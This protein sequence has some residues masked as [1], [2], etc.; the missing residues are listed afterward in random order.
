MEHGERGETTGG[1]SRT[2]NP[3]A[4]ADLAAFSTDPEAVRLRRL[5][6]DQRLLLRLQ[7]EGFDGYAWQEVS[8]ALA[9]YGYAVMVSWIRSGVVFAKVRE[10][11]FG[12]PLLYAPAAGVPRQD[13]ADLAEDTV[14][15]A[16]VNFRD[17]VLARGGWDPAKGASIATYFIGNCLMRF[18]NVYRRWRRR[19]DAERSHV[20]LV[21]V[22]HLAG[23]SDPA[24]EATSAA[25][26][27]DL[28]DSFD[29]RT[30]ALVLLLL[31]GF[32]QAEIADRLGTTQ[33]AVESR[34][35]RLREELRRDGGSEERDAS[36]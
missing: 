34:L 9:E 24:R 31:M 30:R 23:L 17:Q 33:K 13:T 16:I 27:D 36:A 12:G 20:G 35:Y 4:A 2:Y 28:L 29:V 32:A 14:A 25:A 18:P 22:E 7:A 19:W 15:E 26:A 21:D 8:R 6:A 3:V 11:G 10:R 5:E 1:R